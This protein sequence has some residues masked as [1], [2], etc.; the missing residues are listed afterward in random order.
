MEIEK[1]LEIM[2]K[3]KKLLNPHYTGENYF[4]VSEDGE[5]I[6]LFFF[7]NDSEGE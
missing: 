5:I 2:V 7:T 6:S 3:N 4:D 1:I